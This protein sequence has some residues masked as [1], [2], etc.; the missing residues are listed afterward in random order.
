MEPNTPAF[1]LSIIGTLTGTTGVVLGILNY[2]RDRAS[3]IVSL[4]WDFVELDYNNR[5][6]GQPMGAVSIVNNG[7]RPLYIKLV[8]LDLPKRSGQGAMILKKSLGGQKLGEG[9][10]DFTIV[11]S[12]DMLEFLRCRLAAYWKG[13]HAVAVDNCGRQYKSKPPEKQPSWAQLSTGA[14]KGGN[15]GDA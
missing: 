10:P 5:P 13:I 14:S 11:I 6:S 7:R 3:A 12:T 1:V 4:H 2:F 8:Y 9:D 15:S